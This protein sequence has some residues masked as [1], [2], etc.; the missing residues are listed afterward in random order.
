MG[1]Q[2]FLLLSTAKNFSLRSVFSLHSD[3]NFFHPAPLRFYLFFFVQSMPNSLQKLL[4]LST[5]FILLWPN[6]SLHSTAHYSVIPYLH[7]ISH[8][9]N[10]SV[11]MSEMHNFEYMEDFAYEIALRE[12]SFSSIQF[13]RSSRSCLVRVCT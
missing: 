4:F 13:E 8:V 6:F 12:G 5:P 7:P 10:N 3:S 9:I 2:K 1:G 11:V